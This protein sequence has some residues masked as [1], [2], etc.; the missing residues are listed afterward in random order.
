MSNDSWLGWAAAGGILMVTVG[1]FRF[2]S[3][4]IGLFNDEWVVRG[5][6]AYYFV[7]LTALAWWFIAIG[8]LLVFG[9]LAVLSGR[10]WGRWV[11]VVF[12]AIAII[13]ELFWLPVY[14]IWSILVIT[15]YVFALIGLIVARVPKAGD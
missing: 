9:G 4:I 8:A 3:G 7:D 12:I 6:D 14:P 13:S 2:I 15:L 11:G 1:F 10:T 5:F